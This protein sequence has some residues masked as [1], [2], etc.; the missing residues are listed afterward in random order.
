MAV[1]SSAGTFTE[2]KHAKTWQVVPS[3]DPA[4][5]SHSGILV[6]ISCA[7][8]FSC[9]AVG[10]YTSS[11]SDTTYDVTESWDGSEWKLVSSPRP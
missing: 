11:S 10:F 1:G 8:A 4:H 9:E 7:R 3:P 6:G 2:Q 5:S